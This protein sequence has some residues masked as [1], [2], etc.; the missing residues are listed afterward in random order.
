MARAANCH[1]EHFTARQCGDLSTLADEKVARAGLG[2][3]P[4][5]LG[6]RCVT[7]AEGAAEQP[8]RRWSRNRTAGVAVAAEIPRGVPGGK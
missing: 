4:P 3:P 2:D 1:G 8:R 5:R 6:W 7:V